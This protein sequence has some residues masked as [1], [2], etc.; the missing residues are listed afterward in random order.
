MKK[1]KLTAILLTAMM[2][3]ATL[4]GCAARDR[5]PQDAN[6][7]LTHD[8]NILV[9]YFTWSG[10]LGSMSEWIADETGADIVRV[11]AAEEYPESYNDT[12]NR[13]KKEQDDSVCP[14][15]NVELTAEQMAKYDTIFLGYPV[16]WYDLPMPM[17]TFLESVDLSGKTVIPFFSHEGSSDGANSLS[18]IEK[19][20]SGADVR[21]KDALSVRGSKVSG[22]ENE[23]R[24][25]VKVL[26]Y[27]KAEQ[28]AAQATET[29]KTADTESDMAQAISIPQTGWTTTVP[30][31]YTKAAA[32]Q[33]TVVP[34]TYDTKDY[35]RDEAPIQKTAYV[36]LPYGY[37]ENDRSMRYNIL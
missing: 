24:S 6:E 2:L 27:G 16:W 37:D 28:P 3:A 32:R 33:G 25:W 35:P 34:F 19:L 17:W 7:D 30:A 22:A 9:V 8:T 18:T 15:I 23:V 21:T 11:L 26:E 5:A 4:F 36:Y 13:A 29:P 20:A 14:E 12:A 1:T 10:H 31:A